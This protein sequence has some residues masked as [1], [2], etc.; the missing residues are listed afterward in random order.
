MFCTVEYDGA[1]ASRPAQR[2]TRRRW[3]V[4]IEGS[5]PGQGQCLNQSHEIRRCAPDPTIQ[6][7]TVGER[8]VAACSV[9]GEPPRQG[10][11]RHT[12]CADE[13]GKRNRVIDMQSKDSPPLVRVHGRYIDGEGLVR[14]AVMTSVY[15]ASVR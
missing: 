14:R 4:A 1:S 3:M 7:N 6:A 12:R 13:L 10:P 15:F 2:S 5:W 8:V 9:A 11:T